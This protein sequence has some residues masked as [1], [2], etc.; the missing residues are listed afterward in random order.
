VL[1]LVWSML[2]V[3]VLWGMLGS[4]ARLVFVTYSMLSTGT[5]SEWWLVYPLAVI[6][7]VAMW[8][9]LYGDKYRGWL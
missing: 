8:L 1:R 2:W 5:G 9:S 3:G 4:I 6:G 7:G